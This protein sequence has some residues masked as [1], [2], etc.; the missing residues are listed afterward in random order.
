MW[1][2]PP[3]LPVWLKEPKQ[4]TPSSSA[5]PRTKLLPPSPSHRVEPSTRRLRSSLGGRG[6]GPPVSRGGGRGRGGG[7]VGAPRGGRRRG[8]WRRTGGRTAAARRRTGRRSPAPRAAAASRGRRTGR[9][10]AVR[11]R[12]QGGGG[13]AGGAGGGPARRSCRTTLCGRRG[14]SAAGSQVEVHGVWPAGSWTRLEPK[15]MA[16]KIQQSKSSRFGISRPKFRGANPKTITQECHF[17]PRFDSLFQNFQRLQGRKC[18]GSWGGGEPWNKDWGLE[19][20]RCL[21]KY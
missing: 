1:F 9:R 15:K 8:S 11:C 19:G 12:A 14:N 16:K 4:K 2:L 6:P 21:E 5:P 7:G 13:R 10:W 20:G 18:L 3:L 17:W